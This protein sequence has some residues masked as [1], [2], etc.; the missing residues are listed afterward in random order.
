MPDEWMWPFSDLTDEHFEMIRENRKG[1][2]GSAGGHDDRDRFDEDA[3][4]E[5]IPKKVR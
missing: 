4:E 1:G 5:R 2:S 3:R